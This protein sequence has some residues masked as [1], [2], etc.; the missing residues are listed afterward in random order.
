MHKNIAYPDQEIIY[1]NPHLYRSGVLHF[2]L[3]L[4]AD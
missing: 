1:I 4:Q 2:F 3:N